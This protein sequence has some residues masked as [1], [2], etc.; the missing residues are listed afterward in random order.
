[1][2]SAVPYAAGADR[3]QC[4]PPRAGRVAS[5][6]RKRRCERDELGFGVLVAL[7]LAADLLRRAVM[8][9]QVRGFLDAVALRPAR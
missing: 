1:M 7:L 2:R 8:S 4:L 6:P 9:A 5:G 3:D